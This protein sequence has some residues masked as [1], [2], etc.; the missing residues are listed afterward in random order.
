MDGEVGTNTKAVMPS[1]G[2][3]LHNVIVRRKLRTSGGEGR[4]YYWPAGT[5]EDT[6]GDG[7]EAGQWHTMPW[8]DT[9]PCTSSQCQPDPSLQQDPPSVPCGHK[10]AV[11]ND[12]D[13]S[14]EEK[15]W[16][17]I[18]SGISQL[19]CGLSGEDAPKVSFS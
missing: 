19:R 7:G 9:Q 17:V 16:A 1:L 14:A 2:M 6:L 12:C 5:F 18:D 10:P 4:G 8:L 15:P 11:F 13:E 3:N